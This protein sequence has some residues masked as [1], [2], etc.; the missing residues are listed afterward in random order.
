MDA[1]WGGEGHALGAGRRQE[2]HT[3]RDPAHGQRVRP[4]APT[5]RA[6]PVAHHTGPV[7]GQGVRP[8][9]PTA[10]ATPGAHRAKLH[11]RGRQVRPAAPP[12]RATSV[13]HRAR[14]PPTVKG[15]DPAAPA[16]LATPIAHHWPP[17][18]RAQRVRPPASDRLPSRTDLIR[19]PTR[20]RPLTM[21]EPPPGARGCLAR[22]PREDR[23]RPVAR[24]GEWRGFHR[25]AG[26]NAGSARPNAPTAP[27]TRDDPHTRP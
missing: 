24:A 12:A 4:A 21:G 16:V 8:A 3:T 20:Q 17:T 27:G 14:P 1:S 22:Q 6:T 9:A 7:H 11:P 23:G 2:L 26:A 15:F 19:P 25:R 10:R 5:A 13:A 18:G